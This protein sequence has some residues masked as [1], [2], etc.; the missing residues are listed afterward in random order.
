MS[1][2]PAIIM[3]I[4]LLFQITSDISDDDLLQSAKYLKPQLEIC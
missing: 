2:N 4:D 3:P 1:P